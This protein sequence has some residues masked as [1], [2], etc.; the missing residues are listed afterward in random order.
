MPDIPTQTQVSAGGVTFRRQ[1]GTIEIALISVGEDERWQLPKGLVS[2]DEKPE[3]TALREIA[4]ETGLQTTLI[5]PL[6]TIEYWYYGT[7]RGGKRMRYHKYVHY[8]LMRYLAGDTG[9]HDE[10]VNEARWFGIDE[11]IDRLAFKNEK[12]VVRQA[13]AALE[14]L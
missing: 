2:H 13:A 9:D 14:K 5:A 1:D 12:E 11:A 7:T 10:E 6:D 8:Y 4:E 3:N